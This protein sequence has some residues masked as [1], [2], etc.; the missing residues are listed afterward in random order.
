M[1]TSKKQALHRAMDEN[2]VAARESGRIRSMFFFSIVYSPYTILS[3]IYIYS[4]F[5]VFYQWFIVL[6]PPRRT[7]KDGFIE[8]IR[9]DLATAKNQCRLHHQFQPVLADLVGETNKLLDTIETDA[10]SGWRYKTS[11]DGKTKHLIKVT[12]HRVNEDGVLD[13]AEWEMDNPGP[14]PTVINNV[15][16]H[17]NGLY[18]HYRSST[19]RVYIFYSFK[20]FCIKY[21]F[22]Y[23][24]RLPTT[25][26]GTGTTPRRLL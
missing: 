21:L 18:N 11:V 19:D 9:T 7:D 1:D 5:I 20:Y 13:T 14:V 16:G 23:S 12:S 15:Y 26:S 3:M 22:F 10:P 25:S 6:P 4:P 2:F 24:S 17:M 8:H